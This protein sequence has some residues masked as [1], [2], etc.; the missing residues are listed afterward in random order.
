MTFNRRGLGRSTVDRLTWYDDPENIYKRLITGPGWDYKESIQRLK[1]R[2]LA[3]ITVLY[4]ASARVTEVVG[5]QTQVTSIN[6]DGSIRVNKIQ[7][8]PI[9]RDQFIIDKDQIWLRHLPI[10]KQRFTKRGSRWVLIEEARDYPIRV[11]IPFFINEE[12]LCKFAPL[13]LDYLGTIPQG[14]P[15][16]SIGSKR[17]W[18]ICKSKDPAWFPHYFR[19]MGLKFW[20]RYF[21]RDAFKLKK[22]SGHKRWTSLEKYMNEELF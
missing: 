14:E 5:G 6:Q 1:I 17:A 21:Q 19:D 16:F 18:E 22:F 12:P 3:L 8:P 2:D 11:D 15:V 7:L 4:I 13:L 10:I 20:K 9:N